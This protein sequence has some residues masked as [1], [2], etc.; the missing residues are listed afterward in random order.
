VENAVGQQCRGKIIGNN[1]DAKWQLFE[2]AD[3]EWLGDIQETKE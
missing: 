2:P 3:T 1:P